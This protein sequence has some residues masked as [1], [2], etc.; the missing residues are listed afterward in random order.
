MSRGDVLDVTVVYAAPGVE[1]IVRVALRPG[2]VVG[3]ALAASGL[4]DLPAVDAKLLAFAIHGE[5]VAVSLPLRAGDRVE[6]TR[7]LVVDAKEARRRRAAK[8][9]RPPPASGPG[10][11]TR[12]GSGTA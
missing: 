10:P 8:R 6:L 4:L 2:S 3:D 9:P 12:R 7:P 1:A 11:A 5:R